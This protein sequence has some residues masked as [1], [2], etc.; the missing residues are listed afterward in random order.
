MD[1]ITH[2]EDVWFEFRGSHA[3]Q[4]EPGRYYRGTVDGFAE[5]GVFVDI[6]DEVTGL[7]HKSELDSRLE[8]LDWEPGDTVFVQ[9]T[10]VRD[11][12]NVDLAWSI[13]QSDREFRGAKVHDP[14][15][16]ADADLEPE[17]R[18]SGAPEGS[19]DEDSS[20]EGRGSIVGSTSAGRETPDDG[21]AGDEDGGDELGSAESDGGSAEHESQRAS[22]VDPTELERA[23]VDS[24]SDRVGD[25]VRIDGR[26]VDAR[27]TSGPTVFELRDETGTV[28]CAAFES[29]GVRAYPDVEVDDV[30]RLVGEVEHHHGEL[31]VET[32]SLDA[33]ED[34]ERE[35]VA[36]RLREAIEAEARAPETEPLT[37]D[38]AVDA[39]RDHVREAATA[40]RRAVM[41]GRPVV[42]RHSATVDGYTAGVALERA[43]LPLVREQHPGHDAEY[44]FFERRPLEEGV[45][46]MDAAT[47]D[48]SDMLESRDRHGEQLPLVVL[49]DAGGN[50]ESAPGYGLLDV[51]GV[52]RLA[53]TANH[54]DAEI[55]EEVTT[56]VSPHH[57]GAEPTSAERV[58]STVLAT[59]VAAGVNPGERDGLAHLPAVSFWTDRPEGYSALATEAGYDADA[60]AEIR[61]AVAF[62][63]HFQSYQDKREIM[64]DLLF[65]E[66]PEFAAHLAEQFRD[67]LDREI[68]TA[69]RNLDLRDVE[70]IAV[71]V[72]DT[73]AFTHRFDFPPTGILL[74]ALHRRVRTDH[75][76]LVTLGLGEDTL[77]LRSTD[78]IDA[79]AVAERSREA[80]P[81]AGLSAIG[82]RDG[83]LEFLPGEREAVLEA[84]IDAIAAEFEA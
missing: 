6:G 1:W 67:R 23:T 11:N 46:D 44:H 7:L 19:D 45:Y 10:N 30:V 74:D 34:D 51:Y 15:A 38:A 35:T 61:D 65:G 37:A 22:D 42:V 29:A 32:E 16:D 24:L 59:T 63:A 84:A 25:V 79:R 14:S 27:Q 20:G 21:E 82:G 18:S 83:H 62:A 40:I 81:D 41:D 68:E 50:R 26:I 53:I 17:T 48:V 54:P 76:E 70:G 47:D 75:D 12:G 3:D 8:T 69:E 39:V 5:F 60:I 71:A 31:Q 28:E 2:E 13:R 77:R 49:V 57:A 64:A 73:E 36:D 4:L 78:P 66:A 80:V 43:V 58:T 52:D 55:A 72:L 33:L 9:V 56:L